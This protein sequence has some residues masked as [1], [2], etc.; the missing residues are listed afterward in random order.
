MSSSPMIRRCADS[1]IAPL[2][3]QYTQRN[4]TLQKVAKFGILLGTGILIAPFGMLAV[5]FTAVILVSTIGLTILTTAAISHRFLEILDR[6]NA[7]DTQMQSYSLLFKA[8]ALNQMSQVKFYLACGANPNT[9]NEAGIDVGGTSS[10]IDRDTP[11]LDRDTPLHVAA[12]TGNWKMLALL[13]QYGAQIDA[14]NADLRTP[15]HEAISNHRIGCVKT[16]R[17]C[18]ANLN[19]GGRLE[20]QK[21]ST[22]VTPLQLAGSIVSNTAV[23]H[24][25][26]RSRNRILRIMNGDED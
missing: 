26:Y 23:T 13:I 11:L 15:L 1:Y 20:P 9:T 12:R 7:S 24:P 5:S 21:Y 17:Q 25:N 8:A 22:L 14:Q 19:I 4:L 16:L 3:G 6:K 10:L 2:D 18:G